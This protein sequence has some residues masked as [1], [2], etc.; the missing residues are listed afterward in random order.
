MMNKKRLIVT[1]VISIILVS[2]LFIGTTYSIFTSSDIDE[3]ENVYTLGNLNVTYTMGSDNVT[4][5]DGTPISVEDSVSV[6][7]YRIHIENTGNVA[8]QF[9]VILVDSTAGSVINYQYIM[10]QV[11]KLEP[12][13]LSNCT[14]TTVDSMA[15]R[16]VKEGVVVPAGGSADVDVR[17]WLSDSVQNTEVNKSFYAKLAISGVAVYEESNDIDN[18]VLI[19]DYRSYNKPNLDTGL[20]PVYY[21][22]TAEVWK[23]ADSGNSNNSWYSYEDKRWANAVLVSDSTRRSTYLSADVG[24]TVND[25]DITAF[26]VWIPRFKYRVWNITRQ[27]GNEATYAYPAYSKGI[28]IEFEKGTEDSGTVRC[29]YNVSTTS[30][31]TTLADACNY[32]TD[33]ITTSSVNSNYTDAWYTH[34]AFTFESKDLEGF[35]IGKF[36]TTGT[37]TSPTIKPDVSSLRSQSVSSQFT[38]SKKFQN[39]GLSS[40]IDAHMLTNLEWGA[41]AY[42][43]HSIYGLCDGNSSCRD[44][45]INNSSGYYTGRSGGALA[46]ST[47]L[48]LANVYPSNSTATTQYNSYGYY[49][50]K[51]YFLDYSGNVTSTKDTSKVASTTGNITG[52]Y[53]MSGGAYEYVMANMVDSSGAFYPSYSGTSWNGSSTLDSKYYNSYSNYTSSYGI[54]SWNR[55]RLGDATAENVGGTSGTSSWKPSSGVTGSNSD[56][57]TGA[58]SWLWRGGVFASVNTGQFDFYFYTYGGQQNSNASF[59]SSLS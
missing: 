25:A 27:P 6:K 39:Y 56:L 37:A 3:T 28:D 23:K 41:V 34:P 40:D 58:N 43:T 55:A 46:G 15:S 48:N 52:V 14:E 49:N 38:T 42:L 2:I 19:A 26:Y 5:S 11:G 16:I 31:T 59:R 12:V 36:E 8:Y 17:V 51:G 33:G 47:N 35:W 32:R 50:Y 24:A 20:I 57:F 30:S 9:D 22:D 54:A 4:I 13:V 53:D 21:D 45:Y 29:H 18:S 1:S 10:A 44:V 7:P